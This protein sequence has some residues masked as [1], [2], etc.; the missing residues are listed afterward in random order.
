MAFVPGLQVKKIRTSKGS[1]LFQ[2]YKDKEE[3]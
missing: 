3:E 2:N 1:G